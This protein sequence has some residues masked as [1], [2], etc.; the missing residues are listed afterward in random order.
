MSS[1][2]FINFNPTAIYQPDFCLK[3][4]LAAITKADLSPERVVFEVVESDEIHDT[5]HLLHLLSFYRERGFK[6]ALDDLGA[7]F[8]S[9][10]LLTKMRP[11]FIKLDR[12]LV[13]DVDKDPYKATITANLL[14]MARTLPVATIAEG[15]ET[16]GEYAWLKEH[17]ADYLQG[18]LFARPAQEPPTEIVPGVQSV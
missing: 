5:D 13:R 6:V 10:N 2:L 12:E 9:L 15:I 8:S 18:F 4:I 7:G 14:A 1:Y 3:T 11:D 17:G 16:P